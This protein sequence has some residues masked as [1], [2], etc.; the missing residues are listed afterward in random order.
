M[1][2]IRTSEIRKMNKDQRIRKLDE[3]KKKLF[4]V[5]SELS[6][7]GSIENPGQISTYKKAIARILTIMTELD[8]I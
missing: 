8:E 6:S 1:V 3:Y 4:T 5:R 2:L 7:G